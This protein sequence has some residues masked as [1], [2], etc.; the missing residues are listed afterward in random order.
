MGDSNW[1]VGVL[2]AVTALG[3]SWVTSRGNAYSARIEAQVNAHAGHVAEVR[4]QRREAYREL[5][6]S[7]HALAEVFW[8]LEEVDRSS[9]ASVRS[10][11]IAE[12]QVASRRVLSDLT[13]TSTD[14][15][16]QGPELV[17]KEAGALRHVA[18]VA[19]W[20]LAEIG[21]ASGDQRQS[22]GLAYRAF[23]EQHLRFIEAARE[24]LEVR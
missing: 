1:W 4:N 14:V 22:Y 13:K 10:T 18:V 16:L 15:L 24:G 20:K 7:A 6:S 23:R 2:T 11:I 12:M 3:A 8:R 9:D 5:S 19:F 17:A 21:N